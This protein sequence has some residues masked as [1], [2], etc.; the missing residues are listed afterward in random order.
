MSNLT[1]IGFGLWKALTAIISASV[2]DSTTTN[3]QES[4]PEQTASPEVIADNKEAGDSNDASGQGG[5]GSNFNTYNNPEQQN[6]EA[7]YVLNTSSKKFH[8]PHC[9]SV[10]TMSP[11]NYATSSASRDEIIAQGYEPCKNCNP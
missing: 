6:T 11:A 5:D 7:T 1:L 8:Y 10:A 3:N 2:E 9:S 4:A